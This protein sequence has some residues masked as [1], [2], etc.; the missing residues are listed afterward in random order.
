MKKLK[1]NVKRIKF[2]IY[3][4]IIL[5]EII[6]LCIMRFFVPILLK[7]PPMS[8]EKVFQSQ[9]EPLSHTAQYILLGTMGII[10][11]ILCRLLYQKG[12]KRLNVNAG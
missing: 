6:V 4:K 5:L 11:Y 10:A 8:E 1:I 3:A 7:Y 12:V 9:I 2:N